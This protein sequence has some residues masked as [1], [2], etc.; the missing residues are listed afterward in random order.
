[1]IE[2]VHMGL[3]IPPC[4]RQHSEVVLLVSVK[5]EDVRIF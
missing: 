2:K 1:M 3:V 4:E 5:C